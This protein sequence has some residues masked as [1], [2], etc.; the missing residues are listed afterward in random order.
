[1]PMH[2][3]AND[4]VAFVGPTGILAATPFTV[5]FGHGRVT[6]PEGKIIKIYV[7][8]AVVPGV[9]MVLEDNGYAVFPERAAAVV[10]KE[11]AAEK[12]RHDEEEAAEKAAEA[13]KVDEGG[14][15]SWLVKKT[16]GAL[17]GSG[18]ASS[19]TGD[20]KKEDKSSDSDED[21]DDPEG[22]D[23][24]EPTDKN[25]DAAGIATE[26]KH[27]LCNEME[28]CQMVPDSA[29]H[30][31]QADSITLKRLPTHEMLAK[32]KL[33][34]GKNT[35]VYGTHSAIH[36]NVFCEASI[37]FC[38]ASNNVEAAADGTEVI[39]SDIDGTVS[40]SDVRGHIYTKLGIDWV[41]TDLAQLYQKLTTIGLEPAAA[42]AAA[43]APE[44]TAT[45]ATP[46][47]F[48]RRVC[49]YLTARGTG[50]VTSTK[51]FLNGINQNGVKLPLVENG[52]VMMAP[53]GLLSA[54][55]HELAKQAHLAKVR[56]LTD[57]RRAHFMAA[58]PDLNVA[59]QQQQRN[60][61]IC[62]LGNRLGDVR[63]YTASNVPLGRQFIVN[64]KSLY[65][66]G[67]QVG[68]TFTFQEMMAQLPT[69][70]TKAK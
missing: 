68:K 21:A 40:R 28:S 26:Q 16:L 22:S 36:G 17:G 4:I 64:D 70:F 59:Q 3:G 10:A 27:I 13:A 63:A 42:P 67:T 38:R 57:V 18:S 35:I 24:A 32:M 69:L 41:H 6:R 15:R 56:S 7:N 48:P 45:V 25:L 47:F 51:A 1:M 8:D 46:S 44:A 14:F 20:K 11:A 55:K 60:P 49:V 65:Q 23:E 19:P 39:V 29:L 9:E 58:T 52:A 61:L 30:P 43:V 34:P 33:R 37:L 50:Q 54:L 66:L 31:D 12:K 5:C 53:E 62:G 2:S